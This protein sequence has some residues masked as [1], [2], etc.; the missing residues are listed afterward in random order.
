M[1]ESLPTNVMHPAIIGTTLALDLI[2]TV[3]AA[4]Q[5]H[6]ISAN[7]TGDL[8]VIIELRRLSK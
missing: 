3:R 7:N 1:R 4:L 5:T 2:L 6:K 8:S